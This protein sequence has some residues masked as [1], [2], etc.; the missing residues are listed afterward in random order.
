MLLEQP[1]EVIGMTQEF[2]SAM[3]SS[4]IQGMSDLI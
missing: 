3:L 2:F 1:C 4:E